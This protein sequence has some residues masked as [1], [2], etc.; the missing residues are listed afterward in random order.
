[1]T[2]TPPV[3]FIGM[4]RSG[5]SMLGRLLERLGL[6]VGAHKESNNEALF[7]LRLNEWLM[8]QCGARWDNPG[9]IRYLWENE[10]LLR[11]NERYVRDLMASPRAMQFLGLRHYLKMRDI[12][13]FDRPWGWKDPRNTFTLPF[14]LRIFPDAKVIHIRRHG[15]DVAESLRVRNA[16]RFATSTRR[17]RKWRLLA[18]IRPKRGGFAESPRCASLEGGFSLWKEYSDQAKDLLCG[19]PQNR[20]LALYYED[21]LRSPSVE[22]KIVGKFCGLQFKE[23]DLAAVTDGINAS[24]AFAFFHSDTLAHFAYVHRSELMA[25]GYSHEFENK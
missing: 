7:F 9:P 16:R 3:I 24:R 22:L 21:I 5:T 18:T 2:P 25:H 13:R 20:V 12:T 6:F 15:V 14:W 19:L 23:Q 11:W 1:M 17:Y 4:H 10:E 8:A